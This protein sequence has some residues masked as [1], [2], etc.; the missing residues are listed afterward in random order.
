MRAFLS[1]LYDTLKQGKKEALKKEDAILDYL[2]RHLERRVLLIIHS[3]D[4]R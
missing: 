3:I 2:N 4:G 1:H